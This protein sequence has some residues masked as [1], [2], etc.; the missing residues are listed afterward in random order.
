M[1]QRNKFIKIGTLALVAFVLLY[2][3]VSFLKGNNIFTDEQQYYAFYD[4][5]D[6]LSVSSVVTVNGFKV[7]QVN[8]IHFIPGG[9]GKLMVGFTMGGDFNVPLKSVAYIYSSDIMGT[10]GIKLVYSAE[11]SFHQ[12]GDTLSSAIEGDLKDQVSMQMLPLKY[13]VEG[14]LLSMDSVLAVVQ[15]IF[16][17]QTREN[18]SQSF[19]SIE[20]TIRNLE[21]TTYQLDFFAKKETG[22]IEGVL[23]NVEAITFNLKQSNDDISATL[24]N[25]EAFSDSLASSELKDAIQNT[26][27]AVAQLNTM[28]LAIN[29]G[30]GTLSQ[31]I[32]NDTLYTYIT[33][34]T[35]NLNRLLRDLRENPKRYVHFSAI[36]MGRTVLV[37][38]KEKEEPKEKEKKKKKKK[39]K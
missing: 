28:L 31:L 32:N 12:S 26:N 2:W 5:V 13:K 33:N 27:L 29:E 22:T 9:S 30:D 37:V 24:R 6:G 21:S 18:L 34:V 11:K 4:K 38:E 3:G 16:N 20:N 7:G 36:D 35:L 23:G 17:E 14:L 15:N 39:E 1:E 25:L 8:D 10:K 19:A